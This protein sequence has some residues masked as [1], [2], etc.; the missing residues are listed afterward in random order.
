MTRLQMLMAMGAIAN[1]GWLMTPMIVSRLQERDGSVVQT[2]RP[3]R[4]RQV[5]SEATSR[6]MIEALKT[7]VTKDG[8]AAGAALK[9]YVAAGKT[10]TAQNPAGPDHAW[11]ISYAA[12]PGQPSELAVAVL[13]ENGGHG[14][15]AAAPWR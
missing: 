5:I 2:Y 4:A 11:F 10:G 1:D 3:Q 7:V 9:N 8:T 15:S 6:Q 12:Q 13:V 14:A